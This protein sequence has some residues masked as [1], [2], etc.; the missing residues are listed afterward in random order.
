MLV[1]R[2]QNYTNMMVLLT[3]QGL[4]LLVYHELLIPLG[5]GVSGFARAC[6]GHLHNANPY[7][8]EAPV[9]TMVL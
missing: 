8:Q 9:V 3:G 6:S 2:N 1:E 4:L 5:S 7:A